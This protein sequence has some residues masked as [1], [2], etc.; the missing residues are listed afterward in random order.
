MAII[1]KRWSLHHAYDAVSITIELT[2]DAV[3]TMTRSHPARREQKRLKS[4]DGA[5]AYVEKMVADH[6]ARGFRVTTNAILS[7]EEERREKELERQRQQAERAALAAKRPSAAWRIGAAFDRDG[8]VAVNAG[9]IPAADLDAILADGTRALQV[10]DDRGDDDVDGDDCLRTL[11]SSP[12]PALTALVL[13]THWQ[14]PTRQTDEEYGVHW[15]DLTPVLAALPALKQAFVVGSFVLRGGHAALEEL[16]L[17]ARGRSLSSG[18]AALRH[19]AW[20]KLAI[21]GVGAGGEEDEDADD[22]IALLRSQALPAL[23]ELRVS[24]LADPVAILQAAA[25]RSGWTSIAIDGGF[26]D[27]EDDVVAALRAL[28]PR[29][30]GAKV[31]LSLSDMLSEDAYASLQQAWTGLDDGASRL[32]LPT[33][34]AHYGQP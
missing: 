21:L 9:A 30:A 33:A 18:L 29:F 16:Q 14:T 13:D 3:L 22:L 27:D 6:K 28:A 19:G 25:T 2:N 7:D 1:G 8:F 34:Y 5:H 26:S 12:R 11:S 4:Y 20:P 15:G 17:V 23:R 24:H 32:F 31:S 10:I